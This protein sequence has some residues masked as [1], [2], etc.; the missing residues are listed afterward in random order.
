MAGLSSTLHV[1]STTNLI[2]WVGIGLCIVQSA[3]FSGLNLAVFSVSRLRLE[4]EAANG[5]PNAIKLLGLRRDSNLTLATIS[6]G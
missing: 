3:L 6:L 4:V 2:I 5:N 1:S